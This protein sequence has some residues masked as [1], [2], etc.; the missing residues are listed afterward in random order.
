MTALSL[1]QSDSDAQ[2]KHA[3]EQP[4]LIQGRRAAQGATRVS[5]TWHQLII[6]VI[7]HTCTATLPQP[8]RPRKSTGPSLY[9]PPP[10]SPPPL[11]CAGEP[12]GAVQHPPGDRRAAGG[13]APCAGH[14]PS[15]RH[16]H[17]S[18]DHEPGTGLHDAGN[19]RRSIGPSVTPSVWFL[20]VC[21]QCMCDTCFL[22]A[23][24]VG[25]S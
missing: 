23:R 20:R 19:H 22:Q 18:Q 8:S 24:A 5:N 15:Q 7:Y 4:H 12:V 25:K 21:F 14:H 3:A 10:L 1:Q 6:G 11:P 9:P 17:Q 13:Q 16:H 2:P